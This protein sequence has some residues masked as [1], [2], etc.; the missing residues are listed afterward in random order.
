M[1]SH[2]LLCRLQKTGRVRSPGV[3][4]EPLAGGVSSEIW[5]VTDGPERFVV[6]RALPRLKVLDDWFADPARNTVEHDCLA[7]LSEVARESVPRLL[8]RDAEAGL[9]AMEF[10]DERFANW[11][12]E[13]LRGV[14]RDEDAVRAMKLMANIHAASW[15]DSAVQ[16]KF[17]TWPN[18]FALR[19]ESYLLTTGARQPKLRSLFE[20]EAE[21]LRRSSLALVH[22]DFSPKNILISRERL[23][24]LDCE[25]AWFGDPAFDAAFLLNHLFLKALHL[26]EWRENFLRL[27]LLGWSEYR[28]SLEEHLRLRSRW[29][30]DLSI[31]IGRLLLMLM[32]ARMDGK[33]PVEY[34]VE[35][36]KK[37][38]VRAFVG[39]MLPANVFAVEDLID[40]WHR[41]LTTL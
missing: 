21:R 20:A 15:G 40:R 14:I 10:L 16:K 38:L 9:F 26:P 24:L 37:E 11:K 27:A 2:E 29:D 3:T 25:A 19:V 33:S 17:Q 28:A 30:E 36:P 18:F 23:V 41:L 8:F 35:E 7:Y 1:D 12:T 31:R 4:A 6:K 5:L 34:I 39:S 13:L 32:L 22:G